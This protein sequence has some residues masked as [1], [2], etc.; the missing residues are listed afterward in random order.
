MSS[1]T[2]ITQRNDVL[3]DRRVLVVED[4]P[5]VREVAVQLSAGGGVHRQFGD[6]R[7]RRHR[8]GRL[9]AAR[10]H[11]ARPDAARH[12]RREVCRRIR[13]TTDACRSSCSPRWAR[14]RT[15]S[16]VSRPAPTTISRSRSRRANSCCA[17]S[18]SC[19]A[20]SPISLR[21]R[22]SSSASS[23][24]TRPRAIIS[25]NGEVLA[26]SAREF[27][28]FAF[29]LKHPRQAFSREQLLQVGLALGLRRPLDRDRDRASRARED[30]GRPHQPHHSCDRV[31]RRLPA[32]ARLRTAVLSL[33]D[34]AYIVAI[35][36]ACALAV[37]GSRSRRAEA[38]PPCLDAAAAVR[39]RRRRDPLGHRRAWSPPRA[40]CT[41]QS[42]ISSSCSRSP[43]RPH[44][45]SLGVALSCWVARSP[46][47]S[48]R[49][50][51]LAQALG[52]GRARRRRP[53]SSRHR[54]I[55]RARRRPRRDERASRRGP[56][57]RSPPSTR[58][59]AS[60]WRGSRTTCAHR[61]PG[62]R[63]MAE[64]LE[65]D[66][67]DDPQRFHRQMRSQVDHLSAMVDDL[68]E[69]SK[70]NSGTLTLT[71]EPVSLYDLVS[72]AV[73]ELAPSPRRATSRF[74]HPTTATSPVVGD[75]RELARVVG[76]LLM[77]AIQHSP[78]GSAI[79]VTHRARRR[80]RRRARRR[81]C[82]RRHPRGRPVEGVPGRLAR[83][84]RHA[85][86]SSCGGSRPARASALR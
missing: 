53:G 56:R 67:A 68:F 72:D 5:T 33:F 84:L 78:A 58:P 35:A 41:S 19:A 59:G 21:R 29:L 62:L 13:A 47:T 85:R 40:R 17:C 64:A 73:A 26:L 37:G 51:M 80:R 61:S 28:L 57:A 49:L 86:P 38:D 27:D 24:S 76:N 45:V 44:V 66:L 9:S 39:H 75:P 34:L 36:L 22:P 70:I 7:I 8:G 25:K 42:T 81:G 71:M 18:R 4:D 50:R 1:P 15:A 54:R 55:R 6:R 83:H 43:A 3:L 60:W 77:N 52:D 82:R 16:R 30:R 48:N 31:G 79:S 14:P 2:P 12:R 23:R 10:P 20:A 11:R 46:A 74:A 32:H 65:D 69:L 63:A